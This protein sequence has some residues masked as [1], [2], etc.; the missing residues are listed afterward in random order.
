MWNVW[1]KCIL[2]ALKC[3]DMKEKI[4]HYWQKRE[5]GMHENYLIHLV[6]LVQ[7]VYIRSLKAC[8]QISIN[9]ISNINKIKLNLEWYVQVCNC[10]FK[11]E[12][13]NFVLLSVRFLANEFHLKLV[14]V[15]WWGGDFVKYCN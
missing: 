7:Q 2:C 11:Y 5:E 14:P 6:K 3:G 15:G 10:S 1:N 12:I 4:V 9:Q 8:V 13:N